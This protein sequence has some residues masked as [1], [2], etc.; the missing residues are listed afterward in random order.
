MSYRGAEAVDFSAASNASASALPLFHFH[1]N[2]VIL[3]GA[4][5]LTNA[6]TADSAAR[7]CFRFRIPAV[8]VLTFGVAVSFYV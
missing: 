7:F 8:M 4:I 6:E 2:V 5:P 3:L 1:Q